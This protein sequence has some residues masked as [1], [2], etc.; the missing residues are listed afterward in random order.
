MTA[1]PRI[2]S[3]VPSGTD[4]LAALGLADHLVGV[5]HA[6]DHPIARGKPVLTRSPR[7]EGDGA[8]TSPRDIDAEVTR[9]ARGG[10]PLYITD[11]DALRALAPDLVVA[12]SIC[13]VC[14]VPLS[15]ARADLPEASALLELQGGTV[16]GLCNDLERLGQA[17]GRA[18]E[19]SALI[20][21]LHRR[22]E[23]VRTRVAHR[24]RPSVLAL[25]WSDPPYLGGHWVPDMIHLAGGE[26]VLGAAPGDRSQRATLDAIAGADP[27][28]IV[29]MPCG[30]TMD[31][32][33]HEA[34][35]H[36]TAWDLPAVREGRL[37]A[38]D[39]SALF[40]RCTPESVARGVE[41]LAAIL[42]P[43][44][45]DAPAPTDARVVPVASGAGRP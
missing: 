21:D 16:Q 10:D 23:A 31:Q 38:T 9:A 19:A 41:V 8:P 14:A 18:Q 13:D 37:W 44:L 36:L 20:D 11:R 12:Q 4:L 32:A 34:A 29:F 35:H 30:Y 42:H 2:A 45:F 26:H 39:A 5:S 15:Q 27:D 6:C 43:D 24:Q 1:T 28:I 22:I 33:L 3:L 17:T 40:S 25:E 7:F